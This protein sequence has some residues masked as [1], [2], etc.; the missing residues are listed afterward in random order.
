[1]REEKVKVRVVYGLHFRP[2]GKITEIAMGFD[3]KITMKT[4]TKVVDLKSFL[5]VLAAGVKFGDEVLITC[6][7]ED[8]A[9]AL[10]RIK[11]YLEYGE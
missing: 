8:E 3:S 1:M 10:E 11:E 5:G 7:G 6:D 4:E 2:A 9:D